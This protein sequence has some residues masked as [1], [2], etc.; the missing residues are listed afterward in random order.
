MI[1]K[2]RVKQIKSLEKKKQ[3]NE[4]GLFLAEGNKLVADMLPAFEAELILAKSSWLA[5]QGDLPARELLDADEEDIRKASLLKNPQDVIAVFRQPDWSIE[6]VDTAGQ[7][8]LALDGVQDPGNL[9]TI[10]RIADWFGLE[11]IVCS[12]DTADVF[13]PKVVQATMGALAR[14]KVVYTDLVEWLTQQ[15]EKNIPLYGTLLDGENIYT[16]ELTETGILIMGNEGNGISPEIE[17]L[18][19]EKLFI[20][21]FPAGR[22]TSESLNVATATAIVCAEFRRRSL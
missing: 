8:V 5:T 12:P 22:D 2:N 4:S 3:R 19:N 16:K 9:G 15:K 17:A 14:V 1:S 10:I 7:L 6:A 11:S 18:V 21:S 13:N 20:P